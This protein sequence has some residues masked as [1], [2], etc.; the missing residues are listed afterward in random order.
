MYIKPYEKLALIY[1][2]LMSHVNY[3]LWAEY[4][5]NLFQYTDLKIQI[6]AD[7]SVGTGNLSCY[8]NKYGFKCYG[9]DNSY[10]MILQ[11]KQKANLKKSLFIVSDATCLAYAS[12]KFDAVLFLYD[13]LNYITDKKSLNNFL[14]EVNTVLKSNGLLIFDTIT[15]KLC[16]NYYHNFEEE[17]S[18]NSSGYKRHGY[19][20][21]E[22]HIQYNEFQIIIDGKNF[23]ERHQQRVYS[24]QEIYQCLKQTGFKILA[25]LDDFTY[26]TSNK[27]S[28]RIHYVCLKS[29]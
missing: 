28:E 22:N 21:Q 9:S 11:T 23:F 17:E 19:Y 26:L 5:K 3:K 24:E 10:P 29:K 4:I 2:Q 1:D 13:S 20:D 16:K 15:D 8:L 27:N 7:I 14:G 25:Q 18:W 6:L 12:N